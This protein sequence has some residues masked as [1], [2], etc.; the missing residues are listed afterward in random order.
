MFSGIWRK[1]KKKIM[2]KERKF[3]LKEFPRPLE[4]RIGGT[5]W[6]PELPDE[7]KVESEIQY[8]L[9]ANTSPLNKALDMTLYLMR[10]QLFYDG[11]KRIAML[12][13]CK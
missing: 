11:N 9:E 5:D 6:I 13:N 10:A 2:K 1:A 4:V 12:R 3:G 7:K 8:I